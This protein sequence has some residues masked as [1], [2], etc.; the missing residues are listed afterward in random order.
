MGSWSATDTADTILAADENRAQV[1]LQLYAGSDV[2]LAFGGTA[3]AGEG[4]RISQVMPV[5]VI[6]DYRAALAISVVCNTGGSATGGY[7]TAETLQS[8]ITYQTLLSEVGAFLGYSSDSTRWDAAQLTEVDRYVQSG[9]RMFYYPP[10]IQGLGSGHDWTFL[11]PSGV[12][13]TV[14]G[15]QTIDLPLDFSRM[16][17][18]LFYEPVVHANSVAVISIGRML[19]LIQGSNHRQRPSVAAVTVKANAGLSAQRCELKLW[20]VPD[21]AYA[22]HYVYEAYA[23]RIDAIRRFPL[24]GAKYSE[25]IVE[26]CLAVAEMRAN[27]E[28]GVHW[29]QFTANLLAAVAKDKETG[30]R[31]FGYMGDRPD[32]EVVPR[33][34]LGAG[35]YS[36]SYKGETW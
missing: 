4:L 3:V 13:N 7:E 33:R 36:I 8:G 9:I 16:A 23:G 35:S 19:E 14:P 28:R 24:G 18:G 21:A 29:D 34:V 26:S 5:I 1:I 2:Y 12:L 30:A 22:L 11:R 27:D 25:V 10:A 31:H 32:R 17:G 6:D 20:P 15:Q